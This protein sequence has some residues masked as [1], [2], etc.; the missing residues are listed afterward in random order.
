MKGFLAW[1]KSST[2]VKRWMFLILIGIAFT[3]YGFSQILVEKELLFNELALII[4]EFVIGFIFIIIGIV[5]IQ[6]RT[7]ELLVQANVTPENNKNI[8]MKS[9]IFKKKL[10]ENGPKVVVIGG[11]TRTKHSIRRNKKIHR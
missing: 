1:F 3:C 8:N 7:L 2:K 10:Y 11:G 5:F 9:L 4:G 6:K